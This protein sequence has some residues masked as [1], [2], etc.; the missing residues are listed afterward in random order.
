MTQCVKMGNNTP[1]QTNKQCKTQGNS[2]KTR[3]IHKIGQDNNKKHEKTRKE[4]HFQ[5]T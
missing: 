1:K 3:K 5:A 4:E 2:R